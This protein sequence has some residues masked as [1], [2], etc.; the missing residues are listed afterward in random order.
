MRRGTAVPLRPLKHRYTLKQRAKRLA[1]I[2]RRKVREVIA[3]VP[4]TGYWNRAQCEARGIRLKPGRFV[5]EPKTAGELNIPP[6]IAE[7]Q[8][9]AYQNMG[10][11]SEEAKPSE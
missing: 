4:G 7:R 9:E 10:G 2:A 5:I 1:R 3:K 11:T 8:L 6:A